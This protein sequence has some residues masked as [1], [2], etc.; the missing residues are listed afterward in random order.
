MQLPKYVL[1]ILQTLENADYESYVVGGSVRDYLIGRTPHDYD[2]A[3]QALPTSIIALF[4]HT[5]PTGIKYGTVTVLAEAPVEVTTYRKD[6]PYRDRRRPTDVTFSSRILDD[7][8]RR[9]FTINAIAYS[10]T[11]GFYDPFSGQIDLHNR[12]IRTV[13]NPHKRFQEDTLRIL[14]GIRFCSSLGKEWSLESETV[15]AMKSQAR[16]LRFISKERIT[17]EFI[18]LLM[19]V[20]P[21][22]GLEELSAIAKDAF[23]NELIV[24][25]RLEEV[26]LRMELRLSL[27][28]QD[29]PWLF[30]WLIL[31]RQKLNHINKVLTNYPLPHTTTELRHLCFHIGREHLDDWL[32]ARGLTPQAEAL[33][34]TPIF[35]QE[36][37]ISGSD[38]IKVKGKGPIVGKTLNK[39]AFYV[40]ENPSLN[41]REELL[42]L[43]LREP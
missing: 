2:I 42:K 16:Q 23:E 30:D 1:D 41:T 26:P 17:E 22:R 38:I 5:A 34:N 13:G 10:P 39:L 21:T 4:P 32:I 8:A 29:N 15:K 35:P 9:D 40:R 3:T 14:R 12:V 18:K 20:A 37:A 19:G 27:V 36:L 24:S 28:L 43:L 25:K 33:A 31:S 6:G 11:R 7:L